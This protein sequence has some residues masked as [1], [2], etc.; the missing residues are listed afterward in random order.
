MPLEKGRWCS[1]LDLCSQSPSYADHDS[2]LPP[3][4]Q[5]LIN[6][7]NPIARAWSGTGHGTVNARAGQRCN[8]IELFKQTATSLSI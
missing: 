8:C 4:H 6:F 5:V 2:L 1:T 3:A 7:E